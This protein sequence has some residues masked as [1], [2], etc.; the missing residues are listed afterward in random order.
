MSFIASPK[1][2]A[3][4]PRAH[5]KLPSI[6]ISDANVF[7][8]LWKNQNLELSTKGISASGHLNWRS[9]FTLR[10]AKNKTLVFVC[11]ITS[12]TKLREIEMAKN[13]T[14]TTAALLTS[15]CAKRYSCY[16]LCLGK[17]ITYW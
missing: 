12:G 16:V 17:K 15:V 5:V 8:E 2:Q 14:F 6:V 11:Q 7:Y 10:R 13:Q 4:P 1:M 3:L 9:C